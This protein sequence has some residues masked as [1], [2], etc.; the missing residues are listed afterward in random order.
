MELAELE[1]LAQSSKEKGHNRCEKCLIR[2][3]RGWKILWDFWV[4]LLVLSSALYTPWRL[5]F[6]E[7][8]EPVWLAFEFVMDAF[9]IL[10]II[11]CFF[12]TTFDE[13][14]LPVKSPRKVAC[15]YL[16]GWFTLD[17]VAAMPLGLVA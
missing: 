14:G 13:L 8:V 12:S 10:D 7:N 4:S 16:Q 5:A 11:L 17:F 3:D 2:P 9:F 6:L 1:R 15:N